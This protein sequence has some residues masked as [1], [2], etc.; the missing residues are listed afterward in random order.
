MD[1]K[2]QTTTVAALVVLFLV[3]GSCGDAMRTDGAS[4]DDTRERAVKVIP[5]FEIDGT[6]NFPDNVRFDDLGLTVSS[7]TL[8]PID[9][10]QG[11]AY[12]TSDADSIEFDVGDGRLEREGRPIALPETGRFD[13]TLRLEPVDDEGT[14]QGDASDDYSLALSGHVAGIEDSGATDGGAQDGN[15]IPV[16]ASPNDWNT[17]LDDASAEADDRTSTPA[18]WM[19]FE[20]TT[21]ESVRM[22]LSAVELRNGTQYLRFNFDAEEWASEIA[23]P[24]ARAVWSKEPETGTSDE[25]AVDV[26]R[27][28]DSRGEGSKSLGEHM[29]VSADRSG[30]RRGSSQEGAF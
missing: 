6:H 16:P 21:R 18:H 7:I 24:V 11:V 19:P 4:G 8:T 12:S 14:A 5:T 1:W 10:E 20:Y 22:T 26:T 29:S 25:E 30:G 2:A 17:D 3:L 9:E 13:V 27:A 23:T 28:V 15:P